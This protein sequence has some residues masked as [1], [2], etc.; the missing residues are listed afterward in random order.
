MSAMFYNFSLL[1]ELNISNFNTKNITN[2]SVMFYGCLSLKKIDF[3]NFNNDK[4]F[5]MIF[6]LDKC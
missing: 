3:S 2:M 4:V 1:E 5:N 6:I